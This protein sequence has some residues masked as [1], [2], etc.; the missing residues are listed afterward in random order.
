MLAFLLFLRAVLGSESEIVFLIAEK[1]A[2]APHLAHLEGYA[3]LR[4]VLVTLPRVDRSCEHF[5]DGFDLHLLL[6]PWKVDVKLPG[7]GS[8]KLPWHE[9][10]PSKSS[11]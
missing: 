6:L 7:K 10:G 1:P 11:R 5:P 9:A 2:P 8:S 4:I 3:A